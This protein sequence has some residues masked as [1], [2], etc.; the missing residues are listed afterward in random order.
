[1][2]DERYAWL[3]RISV[4]R[5]VT[6]LMLLCALALVGTVALV[7][8]PIQLYPSGYDMPFL[9]VR[10]PYPAANPTEIEQEIILPLEDALLTVRGVDEIN[11]SASGDGG[12]CWIELGLGTD[13]KEAY[14]EVADRVERLE[15]TVWPEDI[16]QVSIRRHNPMDDAPLKVSIAI[17]RSVEDPYW[18][19]Q[20][21]VGRRLERLA[22]VAQIDIEGVDEKQ[23]F[24]EPDRDAL[25]AHRVSI[26]DLTR[27]LRAANFAVSSGDVREGSRKLLVR[28]VA[29]FE[30]IDEIARLPV[31]AD[32]LTL[33]EVA[34]VRYD[35][36]PPERTSRLDGAPAAI[37][38]I[39]KESEAN[40]I[41]VTT[42]AK[43][44]LDRIFED[45][46]LLG[47]GATYRVLFDQG[48]VVRDSIDQLRDTGF[49]GALFAVGILYLFLRRLRVTLL[50]TLAIPASLLATLVVMLFLGESIN[51]ITLMGLL[52]CTG[53]LVDNAIVV[54]E[55]IDR[56]RHTGLSVRRAALVGASEIGLALTLA[57]LTTIIVFIPM[58]VMGG[59]GML[60]FVFIKLAIPVVS[61]IAFSLIVA[62]LFIPLSASV[63][64]RSEAQREGMRRG[65]LPRAADAVYRRLLDPLHRGYVAGLRLALGHRG[66]VL[67]V[68]LVL[69]AVSI[70]PFMKIEKAINT[71]TGH[72]GGREISLFFDLPNTYSLE[73]ADAWF[74]RIEGILE[75][76]R[77]EFDVRHYQTRFWHNRGM[78]RVIL[79]D[80]SDLSIDDASARIRKLVP[81]APGIRTYVNW[82]RGDSND[83][84]VS[85]TLYGEDTATL[86][87]LADEV[88]RRL[89]TLPG[90]VSVEPDLENALE[91]V[92]VR[93]SRE[94]AQRYG[95]ATEA[96]TGTV[97]T[98]LRGQSLPRFR[99][100]EKEIEIRV[101]FPER[102]RQGIGK[103]ATLDLPGPTGERIPLE[104]L[105]DLSI[106]RGF[107]DINR[108]DRRTML[109]IKL[110]TTW[111]NTGPLRREVTELMSG[112][113]L[114][115][116]YSWDF[117]SDWRWEQQESGDMLMALV[118][119][120]IFV[121]FI[122]GFLFESVLLPLAVM[123][124]IVLSWIGAMWLL[125]L[126]GAKLDIMAGIG[127]VLLAGVVVNNGIVLVDLVN[128]LR[129]G[130]QPR[131]E[132]ILLAGKLRF[133]P[134]LM[135]ALTTIMGMLPMAF[136]S[137][138][139]VGMPYAG[140][141]KT[142]VGGLLTS[143]TLT[144]IVVP[145][146][147]TVL[148]DLGESLRVL[149]LGRRRVL[150]IDPFYDPNP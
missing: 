49:V 69:V 117:G 76:H 104:A 60:R 128:R 107:G 96:I 148:D 129:R 122:M 87:G 142:F 19:L 38:E 61:A 111:D 23:I 56:Y 71:R 124:S 97:V 84:S 91:E 92:R 41:E 68:V 29:R 110:N 58:A 115:R 90:L 17:P 16:E 35:L 54:V 102:D 109:D 146:V 126:T 138:S 51:V 64:L 52:I 12:R 18:L 6:V 45:E 20:H 99:K 22:G 100:G 112:V 30:N 145:L 114:P 78:V 2:S 118:V 26:R 57:T 63:L 127:L 75:P 55:N 80:D 42:A 141:G 136:G 108:R 140:L 39:Y 120:M 144:L 130:G 67:A 28:S 105:A 27:S 82:Q 1:M 36:P 70:Y 4:D 40:T 101:Q 135:T 74:R 134:I 32:G 14:N 77:E 62:L 94:Q 9:S 119:A 79:E 121:Y 66:P 13:V 25:L 65:V 15:A 88:E 143:T 46:P 125:W 53:M 106:S 8:L 33:G 72:Q 132:A 37:L 11:C 7:R 98:A 147:Y 50:I 83:P 89:R 5:P 86:A 133:R 131:T 31:R 47:E 24:I 34:T 48:E 116:G 21:R 137:A 150:A 103:L 43:A 139:F 10:V 59:A 81:E 85:V 149:V 3:P 113:E 73:E 44:E 93:V 95:V 123:P